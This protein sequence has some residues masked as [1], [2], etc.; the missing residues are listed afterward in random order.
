VRM[1]SNTRR[2]LSNGYR[3]FRMGWAARRTTDWKK[4]EA[5]IATL[6][7]VYIARS[8]LQEVYPEAEKGDLGR[9]INW[10]AGVSYRQWKDSAYEILKD[11]AGLYAA[12]PS[13]PSEA[14]AVPWSTA[15]DTSQAA[16]NALPVTLEVMQHRGA[17]DISN[18]LMTLSL[19]VREFGLKDVVELGTRDGNST[20]AL[21]EACHGTGGHVTSVDV[22]PCLEAK[23][24]VEKA[25]FLESWT[26]LQANDMELQPPQISV[27][28]DLLLID[29]SHLYEP[30]LAEL[31]KYS[32]YLRPGSWIALHD[33]VSFPGVS[34]AV[35]EFVNSRPRQRRFYSF[36]HQNGLA[37]VRMASELAGE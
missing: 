36:M 22:E 5:A 34:R 1:I 30:T 4:R 20:L 2:L 31:N 13:I 21:L 19:L 29:T 15:R 26:F 12:M 35:H 6:M 27:P 8:D 33:Y 11:Y 23:R 25:G 16:L 18:H 32:A 37:L 17:A 3:Y 14:A 24:R 10:A 7:R 28:I 9:L